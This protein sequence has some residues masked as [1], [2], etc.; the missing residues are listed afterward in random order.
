MPDYTLLRTIFDLSR[1]Y[2]DNK[3]NGTKTDDIN[4][5]II[6]GKIPIILSAP[7]A[8]KSYKSG[9]EKKSRFSN[10]GNSSVPM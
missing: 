8:V 7:H 10:R 1:Q 9:K 6:S 5:K 2:L 4:Y 3:G